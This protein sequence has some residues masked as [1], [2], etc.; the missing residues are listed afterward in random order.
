MSQPDEP[1]TPDEVIAER[2]RQAEVRLGA[3]VTFLA[4]AYHRGAVLSGVLFAV[5]AALFGVAVEDWGDWFHPPLMGK[6][7]AALTI[8]LILVAASTALSAVS[9]PGAIDSFDSAS[10]KN[11]LLRQLLG[12]YSVAGRQNAR[13]LKVS[14]NLF[15]AAFVVMAIVIA[16]GVLV[17]RTAYIS[18]K[19]ARS[20]A[21]DCWWIYG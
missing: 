8:S 13:R 16:G 21:G 14:K 9:L 7:A 5:V 19:A 10:T 2:V 18:D 1:E 4:A 17:A 11:E 3:Q 12:S 6:V 20:E 15:L